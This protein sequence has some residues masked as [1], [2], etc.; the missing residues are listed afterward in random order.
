MDSAAAKVS[1][2]GTIDLPAQKLDLQVTITLA[3][4]APIGVDVGGT[5]A[6][7]KPRLRL[8]KNL[9]APIRKLAQP[10]LEVLKGLFRSQ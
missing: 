5:F 8:D 7:P 2:A 3:N 6:A 1:A 4:A 10:A 9:A